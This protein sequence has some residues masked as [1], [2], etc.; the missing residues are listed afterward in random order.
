MQSV[1]L[2]ST[3]FVAQNLGANKVER[4]KQGVTSA[5]FLGIGATAVLMIPV[6]IFAPQLVR[7]FNPKQEVITYG[8]LLL[9]TISPFYLVYCVHDTLGGALRGAGNGKVPMIITLVCMV[10]FRQLYLYVMANFIC[11]EILPIA[12]GYPAGWLLCSTITLIY[13][14]KKGFTG[15]SIADRTEKT[16]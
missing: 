15:N 16:A 1:A 6:M 14:K 11:N 4:A 3:T 13:Y 2:S 5:L 9:R 12:M 10:G 8:V 7:F